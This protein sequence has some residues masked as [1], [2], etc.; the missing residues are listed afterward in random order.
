MHEPF[1][2]SPEHPCQSAHALPNKFKI[3]LQRLQ[4]LQ[5]AQAHGNAA[6]EVVVR[7]R[8]GRR[9][10]QGMRGELEMGEQGM[11]RKW[12][13]VRRRCNEMHERGAIC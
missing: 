5:S 10:R 4:T 6:V 2:H 8:A 9:R 13:S 11:K 3:G 7:Q 12:A 1:F